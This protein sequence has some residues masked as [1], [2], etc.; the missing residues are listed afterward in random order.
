MAKFADIELFP[1]AHYEVDVDWHY[2]ER[3]I[4]TAMEDGL[5][6]DP[7]FQRAHCWSREQQI[8]YVEY[9][10]KGGEVG[11]NLTFNCPNWCMKLVQDSEYVIVDGKQR[12]EAARAFLRNDFKAFGHYRNEYT[13]RMRLHV[14]F[15]WRVCTLT[16]RKELLQ[17][18][19]N[20]NAG[21]TPHTEEE[22]NKVRKMLEAEP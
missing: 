1:R 21:G 11:K 15:K 16:T 4:K 3:H 17:L 18:Y 22:L 19:L 12:L 2:L 13:D 8:A 14:G 10:I 7:D 9:V 6:L 5:N 20:I